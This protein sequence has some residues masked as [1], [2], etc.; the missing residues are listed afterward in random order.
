MA[1]N[2]IKYSD[3]VQAD[4]SVTDLIKQLEQ[5]KATY[6]DLT[7]EV[8]SKAGELKS[9]MEKANSINDVGKQ[10]TASLATETDKLAK[11]QARLAAA[12][13]ETE[14]QL[15]KLRAETQK[16]NTITKLQT[17]LNEAAEGSYDKL[18]AQYAL[19][20]LR[21][22][23][24]SA[25]ERS[26]TQAGKELEKQTRALYQ[27]MNN[28]QKATGRHV[29][30]IGNYKI[31]TENLHPALYRLNNGLGVLGTSLTELNASKTP[32]GNLISGLK[33][34]AKAA[35]FFM[36]TPL[37]LVLT[38]LASVYYLISNNK[39]TVIQFNDQLL[40]V[41]KTA[42]I[43][44]KE[45]REFG[46]SV[47]QLSKDLKVIDT[48]NLLEYSIVAGQLGVKGTKNILA[49]TEALAKLETATNIKG[50]EGG[51]DIAR[52]LT[53][54]DGGVQNVAQFSDEIVNL[55]NNFAATEKEILDNATS[56]AQNT[57]Q[58]KFGRQYVLAYGVATKAV[59]VEAELTGSSIGRTL[60]Q[61][62]KAIRKGE[63]I[64][65]IARLTKQ[66]VQELKAE[67]KK[68]P[69][70]VLTNLISGLHDVNEAGGS[71][72]AQLEILGIN[73]IRDKRVLGSL[74]SSGFEVLI[75][76]INKTNQAAGSMD[77]EF[78]TASKKLKFQI[79]RISIAWHNLILSI[80]DGEGALGRF[81]AFTAG[82]FADMIDIASGKLASLSAF[83]SGISAA[84][85]VGWEALTS[86]QGPAQAAKLMAKAFNDAYV[87]EIARN[88][89][90]VKRAME[91]AAAEEL[92]K[93]ASKSVR[94]IGE[95]EEA[96]KTLNAELKNT[97]TRNEA[98]VIQ[99]QI[100]RLEAKKNAI[101]G[102]ASANLKEQESRAKEKRQAE[103]SVMAEGKDKDLAELQ[104]E[105]EEKTKIFK[106]YKLNIAAVNEYAARQK[107]AIDKKYKDIELKN[108][109][110]ASNKEIDL[111]EKKIAMAKERYDVS[112]NQFNQE[113]DLRLSEIDLLK[114]T[115]AEKTKL[116]LQAE[117]D[118]LEKILLLNTKAERQL[119][120]IQIQT[121]KNL[122]AKI[123]ADIAKVDEGGDIY[124]MLGLKLDDNQ[125]QALEDSLSFVKDNIS[126]IMALRVE[127]ADIALRKIQEEGDAIQH[128]LD[129][130][131]EARNNGY[132]NNVISVQK[133]LELNRKKEAQALKDKQKA[134]RA[135][136][137]IDTLT[138][139]SGLITASV[140]IWKALAGIP[141]IGPALAAASVGIMFASFAAAKIKARSV[142]K[143]RFGE[144]GLIHLEGGSHA[145]G[146]D[147]PIGTS[148]S[149]KQRTAEGGEDMIIV[150]KKSARKYK[151]ILPSL[152][153]SINQGTFE[154]NFMQ[155]NIP[156]ESSN[157]FNTFS[158]PELKSIDTN[159]SEM[160]NRSRIQRY[161]DSKGRQVQIYRNVK[162]IFNV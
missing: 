17:K 154:A 161:T 44:G 106:K 138:Q 85:A 29:H 28:L 105:V 101:L 51:A 36:L 95:I 41:G 99:D 1:D 27:E 129:Q 102:V 87:I 68:D 96:I 151:S 157:V 77:K 73:A 115:E 13:S 33:D 59:G 94:T 50:Q 34:F 103:I 111:I 116:R 142:S 21:L 70:A 9:A 65:S 84:I 52:L 61:I 149:G 12:S 66:T 144:G 118:R 82:F 150:N 71:V 126:A 58:Y 128:R 5:L 11:Q 63:G 134:Q 2:P 69:G 22:N 49:F 100:K 16:Q 159:I 7:K 86:L 147:I 24:M 160:N 122:I 107:A 97:S 32:F 15:A 132:A 135:Q 60:G 26:G 53:L 10:S 125:K 145:S 78:E 119:S 79:E 14:K 62:E 120:D 148:P 6:A 43:Y 47:V 114:E 4:G 30:E 121:I 37:G 136:E 72:N 54:T 108:A 67:F 140:Q 55:G 109:V 35:I 117:R 40:S 38:A 141:V 104:V 64:D 3:F 98:K 155:E 92:T 131:I 19:N 42:G 25:A 31:A 162:T 123:D 45:L 57:A 48:K 127:A 153:K 112:E 137:A 18:S 93:Q 89:P 156:G 133:E 83:F 158:S 75:N 23:A 152:V 39:D 139:T 80:E 110:D 56:V 91:K 90:A 20:K 143:E 130:E 46:D 76:A 74:A 81:A 146:N 124:K 113:K 88:N 8:K